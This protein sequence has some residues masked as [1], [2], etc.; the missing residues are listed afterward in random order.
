MYVRMYIKD[1]N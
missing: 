1:N